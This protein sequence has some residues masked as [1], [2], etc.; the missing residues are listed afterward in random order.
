[1]RKRSRVARIGRSAD[2]RQF[3]CWST[4]VSPSCALAVVGNLDCPKRANRTLLR[5]GE[6]V[7]DILLH[8]FWLR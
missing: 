7:E 5:L 3:C 4:G 2:R 6:P 1:M 8:S